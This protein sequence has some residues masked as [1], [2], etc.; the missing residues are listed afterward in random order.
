MKPE[1]EVNGRAGVASMMQ[2]EARSTMETDYLYNYEATSLNDLFKCTYKQHTRFDKEPVVTKPETVFPDQT[3]IFRIDHM[4][5]ET[6]GNLVLSVVLPNLGADHYWMNDVGFGMIDYVMLVNG[7]RTLV[8]FTGHYLLTQ[9][10]LHTRRTK[11][12]GLNHMV[13]H[14]N[15]RFSLNGRSRRLY[16]P[17]PFMESHVDRQY[18][19]VFLSK[20]FQVRVKF[21]SDIML[22]KNENVGVTLSLNNNGHV[23]VRLNPPITIPFELSAELMYD[24]FHLSKE[25]RLLFLTQRGQLL[26]RGVQESHE[27][28][29]HNAN[30]KQCLLDITGTV[31]HLIITLSASYDRFKFLPIESFTLILNGVII[32][33]KETDANTFRYLNRHNI[34]NRYMYVIPF[35]LSCAETQ[36]CGSLTFQNDRKNSALIVKRVDT[37]LTGIITIC[38]VSTAHMTFEDGSIF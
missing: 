35:G 32:G 15:T 24:A 30:T 2:V 7:D 22:R 14:Y 34:C 13:G 12:T 19:P 28:F 25:E 29:D 10:L 16:I 18:Y 5:C 36:P 20:E 23:R 3:L 1:V 38:A 31:S 9:F 21:R 11:Q 17:I 4:R 8:Q 6:I 33:K 27:S 26:Y 37:S